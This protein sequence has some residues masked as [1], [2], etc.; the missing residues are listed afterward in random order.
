MICF[1]IHHC[2]FQYFGCYRFL[3]TLGNIPIWI[4]WGWS[5]LEKNSVD[6]SLGFYH[7]DRIW[8]VLRS[9]LAVLGKC[10]I[11]CNRDK[12]FWY[13]LKLINSSD[14]HWRV[15]RTANNVPIFPY[16]NPL[17]HR[18]P[19]SRLLWSLWN[20]SVTDINDHWF[21]KPTEVEANEWSKNH[22]GRNQTANCWADY[23]SW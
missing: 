5:L 7:D 10:I 21:Q 15:N 22:N 6:I 16:W 20:G 18:I 4:W 17:P 1:W 8:G 23:I 3:E 19:H 13:F 11:T 14:Y 9:W 2:L 12:R